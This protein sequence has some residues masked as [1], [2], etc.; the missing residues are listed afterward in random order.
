MAEPIIDTS[1]TRI[2]AGPDVINQKIVMR[3]LNKGR[4]KELY[5]FLTRDDARRLIAVLE[6]CLSNEQEGKA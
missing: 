6:E 3:V 1:G 4:T 5:A 2:T